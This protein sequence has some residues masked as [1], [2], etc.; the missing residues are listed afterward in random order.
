MLSLLRSFLSP[1]LSSV[2]LYPPSL[3]LSYLSYRLFS[4]PI[5]LLRLSSIPLYL[6]VSPYLSLHLLLSYRSL[7]S[8]P[9]PSVSQSLLRFSMSPVSPPILTVPLSICVSSLT[10]FPSLFCASLSPCLSSICLS[11]GRMRPLCLPLSPCLPVS[12][13]L[14]VSP[15][16]L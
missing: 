8:P 14:D 16:L 7:V 3:I 6:L 2:P 9:F 11:V 1:C 13:F 5:C 10:V 4:V 12:T 15:S